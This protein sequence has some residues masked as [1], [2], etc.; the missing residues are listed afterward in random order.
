MSIYISN[1]SA[2]CTCTRDIWCYVGNDHDKLELLMWTQL[3]NS[4]SHNKLWCIFPFSQS[5]SRDLLQQHLPN[6]DRH[7]W[8]VWLWA[9]TDQGNYAITC[10]I[11]AWKYIRNRFSITSIAR[12]NCHK[13]KNSEFRHTES[14]QKPI[15]FPNAIKTFSGKTWKYVCN[16]YLLASPGLSSLSSSLYKTGPSSESESS[17]SSSFTA[18]RTTSLG[19]E[20]SLFSSRSLYGKLTPNRIGRELDKLIR[21]THINNYLSPNKYM[22]I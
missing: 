16:L 15:S 6:W 5:P 2:I 13:L 21:Y 4:W 10:I 18:T 17:S 14:Q 1:V 11:I 9:S 7:T 8:S 19:F 12:E 22:Y 3:A 20:F